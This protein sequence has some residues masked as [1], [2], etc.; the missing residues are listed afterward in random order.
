MGLACHEVGK[1]G[2]ASK[3]GSRDPSCRGENFDVLEI[4][5][6]I[7]VQAAQVA[8]A[9]VRAI[10]IVFIEPGEGGGG[11]GGVFRWECGSRH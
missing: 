5:P 2:G 10:T 4:P 3:F 8:H 6:E 11:E 9:K 1:S 7:D